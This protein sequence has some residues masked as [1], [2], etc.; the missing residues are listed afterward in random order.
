MIDGHPD[1]VRRLRRQRV[2]LERGQQAHDPMGHPKC[3]LRQRV[4][5]GDRRAG[6]YVETARDLLDLP[7]PDKAAKRRARARMAR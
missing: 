1:L 2:E 5:F 3:G 7:A 6:T 4:M